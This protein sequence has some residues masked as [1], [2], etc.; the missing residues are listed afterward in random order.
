MP[1]IS[2]LARLALVCS[3]LS[4]SAAAVGRAAPTAPVA[5]AAPLSVTVTEEGQRV[6]MDAYTW[7]NRQL[8]KRLP[9]DEAWPASEEMG[10]TL[11]KYGLTDPPVPKAL[12]VPARVIDDVYLVSSDPTLTYL[13]DAG[14]QGLILVDPG[15]SANFGAINAA[16]AKLGFS[17]KRVRWVLNTHAHFDHSMADGL[18]R[19][20]GARILIGAADA[21]AVERATRVTAKFFTPEIERGYPTTPV[22]HRIAD[23]EELRLGD[24]VLHAI[25]IPGHTAGS[26]AFHMVVGGRN[27]LLSGDTV[28]FDN[29]LGT[30][31]TAYADNRDYLES[32]RK[33]S[34]FTM[35][36]GEP[37]RW[38][39]L[40]PGHGTIVLDRAGMDVEKAYEAVRLDLLDGG[41][42]EA[43][44]FATT[45]YRRMMFGR[46]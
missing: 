27:V 46:P 36:L 18:F 35:G 37:V 14:P 23:G 6:A 1:M 24:K 16:I 22:D 13:I 26:T 39:V 4:L 43:A 33:L 28:L 10:R 7:S 40:L 9:L 12:P 38:D 32:L 29:R 30:Q 5:P 19:R 45:R 21:D 2:T 15:L 3:P 42:I 41:R 31:D 20:Q 8:A 17:P 25:A 11:A 34:R 44:P